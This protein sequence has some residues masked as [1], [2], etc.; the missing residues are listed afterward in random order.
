MV[1]LRPW[2][3]D[4]TWPGARRFV[5]SCATHTHAHT[6]THTRTHTHT[7]THTHRAESTEESVKSVKSPSSLSLSLVSDRQKANCPAVPSPGGQAARCAG[8]GRGTP[9]PSFGASKT[10][11]QLCSSLCLTSRA[12]YLWHFRLEKVNTKPQVLSSENS[13]LLGKDH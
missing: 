5:V 1:A 11:G 10:D 7:H 2:W 9:R 12:G 6:H 3:L 4:M 13:L 8:S